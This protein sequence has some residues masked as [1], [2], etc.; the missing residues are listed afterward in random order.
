MALMARAMSSSVVSRR[1]VKR[2][3]SS[4]WSMMPTDQPSGSSQIVR[5]GLPL[6]FTPHS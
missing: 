2:C 3:G 1:V 4:V 5:V 6:T